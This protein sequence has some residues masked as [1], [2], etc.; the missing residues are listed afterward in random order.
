MGADSGLSGDIIDSHVHLQ[1]DGWPQMGVDPHPLSAYVSQPASHRVKRFAVLAM[2][3]AGDL[4][5]TKRMNDAVI[6]SGAVDP[7]AYAM[8]SVHPHDGDLAITELERVHQAGA[9]G[10]KL[11]PNTQGFDVGDP[12]V[13]RIVEH[14]GVLGMPVLFDSVA[15]NDPGQPE[16]F[17]MLA[18][19]S[20][21]AQI[22]LAHAFGP[23][24]TSAVM[25][26][27][28]GRYP[29]FSRNVWLELSALA[30]MFAGSPFTEHIAWIMRNHGLDRVLWG[31]DYPLYDLAEALR[32]LDSYGFEPSEQRLLTHDN[33][34][35]LFGLTD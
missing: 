23:K 13:Q 14:A 5:Q 18:M 28:L 35:G 9:R 17:M 26:A 34:V 16:K 29:S 4:D 19:Q 11:H 12:R 32:A 20:P 15:V 6:A 27:V 7:R 22:I 1:L 30:C 8:C 25:F 2:A 33:A 3:P 21:A 31:S 10:I 24:Y